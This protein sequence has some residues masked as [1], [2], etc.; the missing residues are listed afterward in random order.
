MRTTRQ[1]R[2][3]S[4]RRGA[5]VIAPIAAM[6]ALGSAA[7]AAG[8]TPAGVPATTVFAAPPAGSPGHLVGIAADRGSVYVGTHQAADGSPNL[9]SHV[10]RY[11]AQSG[12]LLRDY[13]I[14]GQATTGQGLTN[15]ATGRNGLLYI[16][17]RHPARMIT[18]DPVTGAQRT[19]ATFGDVPSCTA[20]GAQPGNCSDTQADAPAYPDDIAFGPDGS[21]YVTD[22]SQAL[23]WRVPPGGGPARVWL[24]DQ[25]LESLFG[26]CGIRLADPRTIVLAQCTYGL[27]DPAQIATGTGR[28]YTLPINHDG[29]AGALHQIWQGEPGE[30]SDGIAIGQSG[31]IYVAL[32]LG[33]ALLTLDSTGKEITR[34]P[35]TPTEAGALPVPYDNPASVAILADGRAVITNQ[36]FLGGPTS[37]QVVLQTRVPDRAERLYHP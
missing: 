37:D 31:R 2:R 32:A 35:A 20:P 28:I 15:M 19:Y 11:S 33:N 14:T 34:T 18:L 7:I 21:A 16:L 10:Y 22:I 30:A 29:T 3:R 26:P 8:Q 17:D 25:R 24:T 13:S 36:A 1:D 4:R 6:L 23:V 5:L 27:T 9:P 12:Q